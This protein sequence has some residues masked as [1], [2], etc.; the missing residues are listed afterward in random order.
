MTDGEFSI[1]FATG[2]SINLDAL[3]KRRSAFMPDNGH[4][5]VI[6]TIYALDDPERSLD[7]MSLDATNFI[8][9]SSIHCLMCTERYATENRYH[10]CPQSLPTN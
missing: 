3:R 6:S 7:E 10:K 2:T 9:V 1:N 4:A 5:W 8:G